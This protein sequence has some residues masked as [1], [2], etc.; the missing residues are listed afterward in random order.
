M[1]FQFINWFPNWKGFEIFRPRKWNSSYKYIYDWCIWIGF[2]EIR[3]WH[4]LT[5]A[6]KKE[7]QKGRTRRN[8]N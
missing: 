6:D 4:Q 5:G 8:Y 1:K 3:K 7:L 2:W